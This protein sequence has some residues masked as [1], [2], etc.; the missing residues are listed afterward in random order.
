MSDDEIV[1]KVLRALPMIYNP[2]V[3]TLEDSDDINKLTLDVIYGIL[4]AYELRIG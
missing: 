4:I 1:D 3:S 2:K